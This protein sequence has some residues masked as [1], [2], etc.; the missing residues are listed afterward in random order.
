MIFYSHDDRSSPDGKARLS[1]CPPR[2]GIAIAGMDSQALTQAVGIPDEPD[3]L[4]RLVRKR[5]QSAG[6]G[7]GAS[8]SRS[9]PTNGLHANKICPPLASRQKNGHLSF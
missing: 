3:R 2:Y 1:F 9:E 8:V 5:C 6:C 4:A 7:G